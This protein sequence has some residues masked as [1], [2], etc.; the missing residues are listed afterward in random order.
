MGIKKKPAA[1]PF[2]DEVKTELSDLQDQ[3]YR[4]RQI[5]CMTA[6]AVEA[7]LLVRRSTTAVAEAFVPSR[8]ERMP[9]RAFGSL[10]RGAE[11]AAIIARSRLA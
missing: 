9:N 5:T 11:T 6:T 3:E 4:G 2:F 7:A 8:L 1:Y 10:P